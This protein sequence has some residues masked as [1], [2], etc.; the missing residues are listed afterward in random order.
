[1]G[2]GQVTSLALPEEE[3]P[4]RTPRR[5]D[6]SCPA[7]QRLPATWVQQ[8]CKLVKNIEDP[9]GK[10]RVLTLEKHL[11]NIGHGKTMGK[12][13]KNVGKYGKIMGNP[14]ENH[15][16]FPHNMEVSI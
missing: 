9:M 3:A 11:E 8:R 4:S 10:P 13:L 14:W 7:A 2:M 6:H 12:P 16:K 15:G 5:F 1:M